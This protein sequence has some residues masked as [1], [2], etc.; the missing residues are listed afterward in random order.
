M[1]RHRGA[2]LRHRDRLG[3]RPAVTGRDGPLDFLVLGVP[4]RRINEI[5]LYPGQ[6]F[7][8]RGLIGGREIRRVSAAVQVEFR[9]K[10]ES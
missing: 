5:V 10:H 7:V 2:P 3:S 6:G 9:R 4:P 1:R 8:G